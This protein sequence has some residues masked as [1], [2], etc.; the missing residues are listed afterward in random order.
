MTCAAYLTELLGGLKEM[1]NRDFPGVAV[2]KNPPAN[3]GNTVQSL[4]QEDPT[5]R[6]TTKPVHYNY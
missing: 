5:C 4:V 1:T 6:R 3:A 2:V